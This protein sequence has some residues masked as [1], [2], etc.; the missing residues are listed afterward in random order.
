MDKID[1]KDSLLKKSQIDG[2]CKCAIP[3]CN[4]IGEQYLIASH[5]L[6]WQKSTAQEKVDPNNGLLLCPNHD[7]LFDIRAFSFDSDGRIMISDKLNDQNINAFGLNRDIVLD[8]SE[9][10]SKYMSKHKNAMINGKWE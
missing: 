6:P 4:I 5:I 1:L 9:Q 3:G 10:K 7:L 2:V 8:L